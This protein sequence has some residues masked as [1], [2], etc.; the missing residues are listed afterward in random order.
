MLNLI[1]TGDINCLKLFKNDVCQLTCL[2][3][4]PNDHLQMFLE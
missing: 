2:L 4:R 1:N 3:L